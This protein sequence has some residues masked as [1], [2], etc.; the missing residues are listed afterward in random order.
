MTNKLHEERWGKITSFSLL[1]S[2]LP[3]PKSFYSVKS[4]FCV[5]IEIQLTEFSVPTLR[6]LNRLIFPNSQ[7]H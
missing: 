6:K 1:H 3:L 2:Y 4:F 5:Q 7:S